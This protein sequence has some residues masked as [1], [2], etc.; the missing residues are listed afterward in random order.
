MYPIGTLVRVVKNTN[1]NWFACGENII[2]GESHPNKKYYSNVFQG[3]PILS[4]T[5]EERYAI[6]GGSW[7][8]WEDVTPADPELFLEKMLREC[9]E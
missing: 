6:G 4:K 5:D 7:V 9:L 8:R 1:N 3:E 2:V